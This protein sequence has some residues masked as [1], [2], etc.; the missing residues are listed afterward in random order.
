MD[1]YIVL[2]NVPSGKIYNENVFC[3]KSNGEL[4]WQ[5]EKTRK[6]KEDMPYTNIVLNEGN[7]KV[8]NYDGW[9][10]YID[11]ETGKI[12]ISKYTK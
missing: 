2:L 7:L 4:K 8:V 3:I 1:E 10:E 6:E 11:L 12:I 5:I 9:S